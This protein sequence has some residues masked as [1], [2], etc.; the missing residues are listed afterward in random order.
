MIRGSYLCVQSRVTLLS[1]C[2]TIT[3]SHRSL[4]YLL[5][6][7]TVHLTQE[8]TD[9][10][11]Q[12]ASAQ[13]DPAWLSQLI[14]CPNV[15]RLRERI[16]RQRKLPESWSGESSLSMHF[17]FFLFKKYLIIW[18]SLADPQLGWWQIEIIRY[19]L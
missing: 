14:S 18:L 2:S 3:L 11:W 17:I 1:Y 7:P 13:A 6:T 19:D 10:S 12:A 4:L 5:S 16:Y 15:S 9:R 8:Q